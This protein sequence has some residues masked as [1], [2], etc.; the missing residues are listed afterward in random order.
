LASL[1]D[2]V[3]Y[4]NQTGLLQRIARAEARFAAKK[5][6]RWRKVH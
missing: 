1:A 2:Y 6:V 5:G 4:L 3:Q